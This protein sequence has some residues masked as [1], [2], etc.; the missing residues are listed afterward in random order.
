[1]EEIIHILPSTKSKGFKGA[2]SL[3]K[4]KVNVTLATFPLSSAS[5]GS[6]RGSVI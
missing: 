1:M 4:G 2:L 6:H 5:L 3:P